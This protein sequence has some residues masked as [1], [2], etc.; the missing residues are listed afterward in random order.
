[1]KG[2]DLAAS[3]FKNFFKWRRSLINGANS[4]KDELPW[5][6]FNAIAYLENYLKPGSRVFEYGGGGSTLF[7]LKYKAKV[8]T[9][10]HD[11]NWYKI[12]QD[13]VTKKNYP[14]WK[15]Y[16]VNAE[17][18]HYTQNPDPSEPSHYGTADETY[19]NCNFRNYASVIDEFENGFFDVVLVDGRSRPSCI[20]HSISKIKKNGLLVLDNSDR[21]YYLTR[22]LPEIERYFTRVVSGYAPSP[23]SKDFTHTIIWIKNK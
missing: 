13:T 16:Y 5:I 14:D 3:P 11:G 7:F 21:D 15:G 10:E 18:G 22:T 6:T 2:K 20:Q 17:Q 12:L 9:V 1:L 19:K 23:Y 4:V 8:Y